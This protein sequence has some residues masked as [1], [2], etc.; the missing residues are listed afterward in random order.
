MLKMA[1]ET[2]D[3][4]MA[5][6]YFSSDSNGPLLISPLKSGSE[7]EILTFLTGHQTQS[8]LM[9]GLIRDNGLVNPLNNGTFYV[10]RNSKDR[11]E[12]VGLI[13]ST[14][15]FETITD[16]A[17]AALAIVAKSQNESNLILG[18]AGRVKEFWRYYEPME[19]LPFPVC[20]DLLLEQHQPLELSE[21]VRDLRQACLGDLTSIMQANRELATQRDGINPMNVDPLRFRLRSVRCI[22]QG[23]VW[24]CI[25]D[26]RLIFKADVIVNTPE[27]ICLNSIYVDP[28]ENARHYGSLCLS[29]L[30]RQFL[31][32]NDAVYAIVSKQDKHLQTVCTNAGF[33]FREY[34]HTISINHPSL[35]D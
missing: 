5:P 19:S 20:Q 16:A 29:Q 21:K 15:M 18:E 28:D 14:I 8:I 35:I 23:R 27:I 26:N 31:K 34:C 17:T 24:I 12:G 13:G 10:C 22:E 25:K 30:S 6:F 32:Q 9:M 4:T 11:I 3:A 2:D 7:P 1:I 33:L